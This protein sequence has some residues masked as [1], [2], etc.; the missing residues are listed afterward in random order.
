MLA[1]ATESALHEA[2][3]LSG[4]FWRQTLFAFARHPGVIL[5]YAL[6]AAAA[7]A[8]AL[9]RT[10][11]VPQW[12]LSLLEALVIVWRLL[13]CVIT[14]WIVL[15]PKQAATLRNILASN[16]RT[17]DKL[18]HLGAIV[19]NRLVLLSWEIILFCAV[20]FL[21]IG[22]VNASARLWRG[23]RA[24]ELE[25]RQ[26]ERLALAAIARNLLLVPLALIYAA[27]FLRSVFLRA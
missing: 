3:R 22:L 26:H 8:W 18:E 2:W 20:F 4:E 14:V 19:G 24:V 13:M 9:L 5:L 25:Q 7:R 10:E 6:P 16:A 15:T 21:L 27:V 17:Q 23:G 12:W 1:L 11:P